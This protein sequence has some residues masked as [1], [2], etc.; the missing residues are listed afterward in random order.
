MVLCIYGFN[1][2]IL[3]THVNVNKCIHLHIGDIKEVGCGV[4]YECSSF[5][6][7]GSTTDIHVG[8]NISLAYYRCYLCI[9][10]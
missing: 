3:C 10:Y 9:F 2:N 5:R 7:L 4:L 6:G 8:G 1:I